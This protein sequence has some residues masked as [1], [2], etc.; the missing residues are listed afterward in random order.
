M[1]A[2]SSLELLLVSA[3]FFAFLAA[4][5]PVING[6]RAQGTQAV[7]LTYAELALSDLAGAGEEVHILG[8][9]NSREVFLRM[10][11]EAEVKFGRGN[12][13]ITTGNSTI[14]RPIRFASMDRLK[15]NKGIN[16]IM[17]ENR[18]GAVRFSVIPCTGAQQSS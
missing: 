15:L 7:A 5:V 14:S 2:Q 17:V 4:W 12:A 3:A 13:T 18:G 1:K 10:P 6:V 8:S 16:C 11:E 9:G